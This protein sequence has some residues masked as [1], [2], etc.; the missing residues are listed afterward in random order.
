MGWGKE[1][2]ERKKEKKWYRYNGTTPRWCSAP[3]ADGQTNWFF[4]LSLGLSLIFSVYMIFRDRNLLVR[5]IWSS[6]VISNQPTAPLLLLAS[7]SFFRCCFQNCPCLLFMHNHSGRV[8]LFSFFFCGLFDGHQHFADDALRPNL[9]CDSLKAGNVV[10]E[11][12]VTAPSIPIWWEF[13]RGG[14][15]KPPLTPWPIGDTHTV[16]I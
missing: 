16:F 15:C 1:E 7:L 13:R 10:T 3:A 12:T 5:D 9:L 11:E 2:E 14:L 8:Q 6:T 4:P